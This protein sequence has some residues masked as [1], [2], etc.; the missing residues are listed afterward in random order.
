MS[1]HI[2]PKTIT[3]N[4]QEL[5]LFTIDLHESEMDW[6]TE[7][8]C[9]LLSFNSVLLVDFEP[10]SPLSKLVLDDYD[11][12]QK[13]YWQN[14]SKLIHIEKAFERLSGIPNLSMSLQYNYPT[15][16]GDDL[17][18]IESTV[19]NSNAVQ[20]IT[21]KFFVHIHQLLQPAETLPVVL[22]YGLLWM[23][24]ETQL[25]YVELS[26]LK[27]IHLLSFL[28][29]HKD[30]FNSI[31]Q[32]IPESISLYSVDDWSKEPY[33][34]FIE[35]QERKSRDFPRFSACKRFPQEGED[36]YADHVFD[37]HKIG[38]YFRALAENIDA[39][40]ELGQEKLLLQL[41][42]RKFNSKQLQ[43]ALVAPASHP[44]P[45]PSPIHITQDY[46]IMLP[47]FQGLEI[48]LTPLPKTVFFFFLHHPEGILFKHLPEYR[49]EI[50]KIYEQLANTGDYEKMKQS[51]WD[52]TNPAHNS[53]N[54][55]CSRIKEAFVL[56]MEESIAANYFLQSGRGDGKYISIARM[57][58]MVH[59]EKPLDAYK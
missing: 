31:T 28:N 5:S 29:R 15:L 23:K 48:K 52:V 36:G 32:F 37:F 54:E 51:I 34:D 58:D 21:K 27:P 25:C 45:S 9:E 6:N 40:K 12:I 22:L 55:K 2:T 53:I 8:L 57:G 56:Q 10:T 39:L 50:L 47:D 14:N 24:N 38:G 35:E 41:I 44:S 1:N 26:A 18:A 11:F 4:A 13:L 59:W 46:K 20:S 30:L 42:A 43:M 49:Q 16:I 17:V 3:F 33:L 19:D 7:F